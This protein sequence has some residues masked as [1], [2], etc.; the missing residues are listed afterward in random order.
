MCRDSN[1][2]AVRLKFHLWT[3]FEHST[4]VIAFWRRAVVSCVFNIESLIYIFP[5]KIYEI[6]TMVIHCGPGLVQS[7]SKHA[8]MGEQDD[9]GGGGGGVGD[10]DVC[11]LCD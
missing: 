5:E 4:F 11:T 3:S 8:I 6:S 1:Y 7:I 10:G 9:D 2:L